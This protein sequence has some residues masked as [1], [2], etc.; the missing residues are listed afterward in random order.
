MLEIKRYVERTCRVYEI[1]TFLY[2]QSLSYICLDTAKTSKL[3][4]KSGMLKVAIVEGCGSM[5]RHTRSYDKYDTVA[6]T[7]TAPA[8]FHHELSTFMEHTSPT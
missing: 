6:Y 8:V 1:K 7:P 3:I 2:I 5:L 4:N